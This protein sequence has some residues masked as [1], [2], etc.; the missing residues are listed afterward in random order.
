[1]SLTA[2]RLSAVLASV[3]LMSGVAGGVAHSSPS[4]ET[5]TV[6]LALTLPLSADPSHEV[7]RREEA[8]QRGLAPEQLGFRVAGQHDD[9]AARP[10]LADARDFARRDW[11]K[12]LSRH[13]FSVGRAPDVAAQNDVAATVPPE[14]TVRPPEGYDYAEL[15]DCTDSLAVFN[16][17]SA[18]QAER[19]VLS[20][21]RTRNGVPVE[22]IGSASFASFALGYGSYDTPSSATPRR[23]QFQISLKQLIASGTLSKAKIGAR[24][25]CEGVPSPQQCAVAD[26]SVTRSPSAW[27]VAPSF[28]VTVT[29]SESGSTGQ[30]LVGYG[31]IKLEWTATGR[32]VTI[33]VPTSA[34]LLTRCDSSASLQGTKAC[35]FTQVIPW[36]YYSRDDPQVAE[37][38]QHVYDAY[39]NPGA[40][41]PIVVDK[42]IPGQ[43]PGGAGGWLHRSTSEEVRNA[44]RAEAI[45]VCSTFWPGYASEGKDCD[46]FP[47]AS[48]WEGASRASGNFSARPVLSSH[49][50]TAGSW[51][52]RFYRYDRVLD[53][54][55]FGVGVG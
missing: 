17:Y 43:V 3:A 11:G 35:I 44:N 54:D 6:L 46:E 49:N 2:K 40:T 5:G 28:Y 39:A 1:M 33:V 15:A 16:H 23:M 51:L 27:G 12:P 20:E 41:Y 36:I 52:G 42:L 53:W 50:Q 26:G 14:I 25:S 7:A 18:C 29:S 13:P 48:T 4:E 47:F 19:I 21:W 10:S 38:A 45:A 9:P 37:G 55:P 8:L 24:V 34:D 32:S 22:Q 31:D 30:D